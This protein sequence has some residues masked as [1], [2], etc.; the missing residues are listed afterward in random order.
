MIC[1]GLLSH[2]DDVVHVPA[3]SP[4]ACQQ[5]RPGGVGVGAHVAEDVGL[6]VVHPR[7]RAL[8]GQC[9]DQAAGFAHRYHGITP[10]VHDPQHR[11]VTPSVYALGW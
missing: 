2:P 7:V 5:G 8:L 3:H 9:G 10:V 4:R 11:I 6:G 1:D